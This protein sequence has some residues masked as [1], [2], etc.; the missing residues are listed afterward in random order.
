MREHQIAQIK[1]GKRVRRQL[2]AMLI[3]AGSP[4]F[5]EGPQENPLGTLPPLPLTNATTTPAVR[6]NP[7]CE[8]E[9]KPSQSK[10]HLTTGAGLQQNTAA[11]RP[12]GAAI[13]LNPVGSDQQTADVGRR[14]IMII[15]PAHDATVQVNPLIQSTHR[16]N[17]ELVDASLAP[18]APVTQVAGKQ[19]L[20][21]SQ[22]SPLPVSSVL[23]AN[24]SSKSILAV[25][26]PDKTD[27][28]SSNAGSL[29]EK[30]AKA[31][32]A[33]PGAS[34][35]SHTG[36]G[37]SDKVSPQPAAVEPVE[38]AATVNK[39]TKK[40]Q[41]SKQP[42]S[43]DSIASMLSKVSPSEPSKPQEKKATPIFFSLS[44]DS[45]TSPTKEELPESI[46]HHLSHLSPQDQDQNEP[47][48]PAPVTVKP[49]GSVVT[50]PKPQPK[51]TNPAFP[52]PILADQTGLGNDLGLPTP[53]SEPKEV[54]EPLKMPKMPATAKLLRPS[55]KSIL[56]V[57]TRTAT[58]DDSARDFSSDTH[59][60]K[61]SVADVKKFPARSETS[62]IKAVKPPSPDKLE[63]GKPKLA[64]NG[65]NV[66]GP[67]SILAKS[68]AD[69]KPSQESAPDDADSALPSPVKIPDTVAKSDSEQ[70]PSRSVIKVE[71]PSLK[72]NARTNPHAEKS[73]SVAKEELVNPFS[74]QKRTVISKPD[75]SPEIVN[76]SEA[77]HVV[78]VEKYKIT[79]DRPK[80]MVGLDTDQTAA[81]RSPSSPVASGVVDPIDLP[82]S[83]ASKKG[84]GAIAKSNSAKT[85][86]TE[87]T[88]K[89]ES[90]ATQTTKAP[91]VAA[92]DPKAVS[93]N[94]QGQP[95][96]SATATLLQK[97]Y[98]PPVAVQTIPGSVKRQTNV[99]SHESTRVQ[100]V[101]EMVLGNRKPQPPKIDLH[102]AMRLD[103]ASEL[104]DR[105][106]KLG[107]NVKL[108][109]LHMNQAQVR[110]L[111]L[112]G[113][114]RGVRV[115]D[116]GV[117]QAF[118][119]GPNQLKLIGTGIGTTQLVVWAQKDG[120]TDE[121]LMRAFEIHVNEVVPTEGNSIES[122]TELL[123]QSIQKVFPSC[124][125]KIQIT[126]G[127][128][129]VTGNCDSQDSAERII[130]MVRKS[131]LIP[132]RDQLTV[133]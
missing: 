38:T 35:P 19:A 10:V 118:A 49:D 33:A 11:L 6:S 108:T 112:G 60:E 79:K 128:L 109:P 26:S 103:T 32:K 75:V 90:V 100:A 70:K 25:A 39:P 87:K 17:N 72:E 129:W 78:R 69:T 53:V 50:A 62:T 126:R 61:I 59:H 85:A 24:P 110:S 83:K 121:V 91:L 16:Q 15:G 94:P 80:V 29:A 68:P 30:S 115:G 101:S 86:N 124:D 102:Q 4:C 123:N 23:A 64:D 7:F 66:K 13:G 116:K 132:V 31:T 46:A 58:K 111:T 88:A 131:C 34:K 97:R 55:G 12:I 127:E 54:E 130:R 48:L 3:L 107:P 119:S 71:R 37:D 27:S 22:A 82:D 47:S 9:S 5:A 18:V 40:Q 36:T 92:R 81:D 113:S 95:G 89:T 122:I 96:T 45:E 8:P 99:D 67:V 65:K 114:V 20:A 44:D 73:D 56:A 43:G 41:T 2:L 21:K 63:N 74:N 77:T 76:P 28:P 125:V 120:N 51:S 93:V 105:G 57:P 104:K 106:L 117:C 133:K 42:A 52:E 14:P 98:R 84:D 1:R